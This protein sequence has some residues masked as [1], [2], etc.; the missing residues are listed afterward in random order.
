M[1]VSHNTPS[2][3]RITKD[4]NISKEMYKTIMKTPVV[5]KFAK[6]YNATMAI[7]PFF[8]SREQHKLQL[9]LKFYEITPK[10]I[11]RRIKNAISSEVTTKTI[12]LKTHAVDE[13]GLLKSLS[14]TKS[15]TLTKIYKEV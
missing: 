10:N 15:D 5:K 7:E 12:L 11:F 4:P 1:K 3:G 13:E 14:K 8:S 2:F 6:R 9:G